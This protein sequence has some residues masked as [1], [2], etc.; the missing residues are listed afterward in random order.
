MLADIRAVVEKDVSPQLMRGVIDSMRDCRRKRHGPLD[1]QGRPGVGATRA[2]ARCEGPAVP[3]RH[4]RCAAVKIYLA[5]QQPPQCASL[6]HGKTLLAPETPC[7]AA[8]FGS[9]PLSR[10]R[11]R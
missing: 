9:K 7:A 11:C 1:A 6:W 5:K 2:A 8:L 3:P 4:R 10:P